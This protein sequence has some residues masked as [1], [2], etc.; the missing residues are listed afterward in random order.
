MPSLVTD[1]PT[2]RLQSEPA[3][4][5]CAEWGPSVCSSPQEQPLRALGRCAFYDGGAP[6]ALRGALPSLHLFHLPCSP[7]TITHKELPFPFQRGKQN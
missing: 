5:L 4:E 3:S 1:V 7:N 2:P 6:Q